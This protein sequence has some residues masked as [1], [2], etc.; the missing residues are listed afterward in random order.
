MLQER[1]CCYRYLFLAVWFLVVVVVVVQ[2]HKRPATSR[3]L[4]RATEREGA[5]LSRFLFRHLAV[6]RF[7]QEAVPAGVDLCGGDEMAI[8][9]SASIDALTEGDESAA[10]FKR[11]GGELMLRPL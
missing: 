10:V 8:S 7:F 1:V 6:S 2:Q 4:F 9:L 3:P 5:G 11:D